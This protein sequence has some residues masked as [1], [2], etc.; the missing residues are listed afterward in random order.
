MLLEKLLELEAEGWYQGFLDGLKGAG[1]TG[2]SEALEKS[3]FSNIESLD[4]PKKLLNT[5]NSTVKNNIN[6]RDIVTHFRGCL[7]QREI[8]EIEQEMDNKGSTAGAE[9]LIDCLLRSD[10]KEWPKVFSLALEDEGCTQILEVW[11]PGRDC[12]REPGKSVEEPEEVTSTFI[13]LQYSEEPEP[14]NTRLLLASVRLDNHI[15]SSLPEMESNRSASV[16]EMKLRLYQEELAQ[17]AYR[18]KNTIICAP[19]GSG[20]T[21]VALAICD[22]HLKSMPKGQRGKVVFMATKVPVYEQQK[23]V[24]SKYFES[25][26]YTVAGISGESAEHVPVGLIIEN[27]DIIIL[28]PQILVNCLENGC[29]PS[30]SNFTL[31]IFDECHNTT[32]N[33]PYNVLMFNYLNLK[34]NSDVQR[35]PQIIGLTASVGTGK[36]KYME[37]AMIYISKLCASLDTEVISTVKE[38]VEELEKVISRPQKF[39]I[40]AG[41]RKTDPF[42]EILSVIMM[43][44][45]QM[46]KEVY[47]ALDSMSNMQN[48]SFGT[49]TYEQWIVQTQKKCRILQMENKEEEMRICRALFTFTEHLRKYNDSLMINDDARTKDALEYLQNFFHNVRNGAYDHIEEQLAKNFEAKQPELLKISSDN[50][51]ENPKLDEI[52]FILG[53]VYTESPQT[54]T[55]LFVKSRALVSALKLWIEETPALSFLNPDMLIGRGR[56]RGSSGMTLPSQKGV[57]NAFKTTK[58]SKMLIATSVADEGIDIPECNLVLLYEYVGNVTKMIQVRGTESQ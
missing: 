52:K 10:K 38:H 55:L 16:P 2:L 54:R 28:T 56:T 12:A 23:D 57:L 47:P 37:E 35:L 43:E 29:V 24:F 40:E 39:I 32:G 50:L 19:T 11:Y 7:L 18:G 33:H 26:G 44:T 45:E 51:N 1:Y 31:M 6:P 14:E 25:S 36:S 17:P 20:K 46:A 41:R 27:N 5:I 34:L 49:Q 53:E 30:I 4:E 22:E 48:R 13:T 3:D 21:I 15:T 9:K 58:E 42:A 8:E